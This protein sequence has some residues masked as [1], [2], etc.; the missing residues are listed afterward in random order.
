M[1]L[2]EFV[3]ILTQTFGS[4]ILGQRMARSALIDGKVRSKAKFYSTNPRTAPIPSNDLLPSEFWRSAKI[5]WNDLYGVIIHPKIFVNG[6]TPQVIEYK[7]VYSVLVS[8]KE[9][10]AA[11]PSSFEFRKSKSLREDYQASSLEGRRRGPRPEQL[12]RVRQE[13]RSIPVE[14]L[15][16]M[17][18][19]AMKEQFRAS[20]D[21]CRKARD[22]ILSEQET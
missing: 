7:E 9:A 8:K 2:A 17:K 22:E 13:M 14:E 21:T 1:D 16:S 3:Q 15:R 19:E 18:E 5:N 4:V 20:R 10:A 11:W 6:L 12:I